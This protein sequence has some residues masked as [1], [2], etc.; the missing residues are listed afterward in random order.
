[1]A[2]RPASKAP[3]P[4]AVA[5]A[6]RPPTALPRVNI[7]IP[8]TIEFDSAPLMSALARDDGAG[9]PLVRLARAVRPS[10]SGA[11]LR[12]TPVPAASRRR[13]AVCRIRSKRCARCSSS[14]VVAFCLPMR[15]GSARRS[16]PA[17]YSRNMRCAAWPSAR[18]VLTP[19]SLVGQ[20][21]EELETKFGL[22]FATSLRALCCARIR[23]R[24]GPRIAS[25][26]RSPPRGGANTPSASSSANSISSS[27][28]RRIICATDRAKAGSSSISST[29]GSCSCCRRRRCRTI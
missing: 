1:M 19:A 9:W 26:L 22:D 4:A 20:W 24:S 5:A 6:P 13:R 21:R 25:L 17:W 12:R 14:S 2:A 27:S 7:E 8:F 15:S 16:K 28:T 23:R 3:P 11:G 18:L 29:S 10:R